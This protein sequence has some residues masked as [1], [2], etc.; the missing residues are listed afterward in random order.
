MTENRYKYGKIYKLTSEHINKIYVG[1]TCKKLLSQRLAHHNSGYKN[2]KKGNKR[3]TTSFELFEL[4]SVQITLLEACPCNTKD[5]LLYKERYW[6]EQYKD[7]IVNKYRPIIT[8]EEHKEQMR[9]QQKQYREVNKEQ[10]REQQ[11]QYR[12][13]NKEKIKE[14]KKQYR[15]VNKEKIKEHKKEYYE[16]TKEQIKEHKKEYYE[17]NKDKIKERQRQKITCE[18]GSIISKREKS[19]HEKTIKHNNFIKS[20]ELPEI[21]PAPESG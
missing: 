13:V 19:K 20:E 8:N 16:A 14:H 2:W 18:C 4:G 11:K 17:D 15:E 6:I 7:I 12:E 10:M 1:S 5:E 3:Y 9:E 21:T